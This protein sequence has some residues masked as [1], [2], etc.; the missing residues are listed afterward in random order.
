VERPEKRE[1]ILT[2]NARKQVVL[3]GVQHVDSFDETHIILNTDLGRLVMRGHDL[4]IQH[5]DLERGEFEA[6]GEVDSLTYSQRTKAKA[7][8][9]SGWQKLWG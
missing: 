7:G 8:H 5:L 2:L 6:L 9:G 1:H 3:S 4:K